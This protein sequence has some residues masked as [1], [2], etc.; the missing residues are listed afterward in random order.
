MVDT[1]PFQLRE[2]SFCQAAEDEGV[3]CLADH[4]AGSD[5]QISSQT[6]TSETEGF[7]AVF[8]HQTAEKAEDRRMKMYVEMS[9]DVS[10]G[11]SGCEKLLYLPFN[12]C[13]Y[14]LVQRFEEKHPHSGKERIVGKVTLAVPQGG[15][16][17][18]LK[19]GFPLKERKMQPDL[20]TGVLFGK[21]YSLF[22]RR[23]VYHQGSAGQHPFLPG[24]YNRAIYTAGE[25]EIIGIN[26]KL[27]HG[28]LLGM[29]KQITNIVIITFQ[30]PMGKNN[31]LLPSNDPKVAFVLSLLT[32][33]EAKAG[34]YGLS[35][36]ELKMAFAKYSC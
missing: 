5:T 10:K 18:M 7:N 33:F 25:T 22:K 16:S 15:K 24:L 9:V 6:L 27:F 34:C 19:N 21:R 36:P 20:Q 29:A 30:P 2:R 23:T 17:P 35:L 31:C 11:E 1:A 4:P 26:D 14:L 3:R 8:G 28:S 12:L 13:P 32:S